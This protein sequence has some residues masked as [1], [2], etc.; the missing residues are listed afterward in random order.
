[1]D[2]AKLLQKKQEIEIAKTFYNGIDD[3][4]KEQSGNLKNELGT[5][6]DYQ[7]LSQQKYKVKKYDQFINKGTIHLLYV[8]FIIFII[9]LLCLLFRII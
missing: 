1:M 4:F 5:I 3:T 7:Q 9:S 8:L 2:K 6:K